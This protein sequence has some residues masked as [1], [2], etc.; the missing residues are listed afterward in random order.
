MLQSK[1]SPPHMA[2]K[3]RCHDAVNGMMQSK[4]SPPHSQALPRYPGSGESEDSCL[5]QGCKGVLV[6]MQHAVFAAAEG[7][8]RGGGSR[9]VVAAAVAAAARTCMGPLGFPLEP[10]LASRTAAVGKAMRL[11]RDVETRSGVHKH[12]LGATL[13]TAYQTGAIGHDDLSFG[14][15]V[16]RAANRARHQAFV[17]TTTESIHVPD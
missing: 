16:Q 9:Q 8:T 6:V 1:P 13:Q 3:P 17:S 15:R 4:P 12:S 10:E 7:A 5:D 2:P 11:H 14:R